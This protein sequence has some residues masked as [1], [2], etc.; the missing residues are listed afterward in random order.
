MVAIRLRHL[1]LLRFLEVAAGD[2]GLQCIV[3]R[4]RCAQ[5]VVIE[6]RQGRSSALKVAPRDEAVLPDSR[7]NLLTLGDRVR[8]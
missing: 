1:V 2:H 6:V 8:Q 3:Q 7:V 5:I 4:P